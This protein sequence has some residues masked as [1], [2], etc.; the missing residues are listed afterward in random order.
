M[1]IFLV[2]LPTIM[3]TIFPPRP[4]YKVIPSHFW[5]DTLLAIMPIA[6]I[7]GLTVA[8]TYWI[9][10]TIYPDR[11][12]HVA[13]VT[14]LTATFFGVYMVFLVARMSGVMLD[15]KAK[16]AR[17]LYLFAVI[18]VALISFGTEFAR[19]FFDFSKPTVWIVWPASAVIILAAIVQWQL[20]NDRR[21][22]TLSSS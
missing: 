4:R 16:I 8:F 18:I 17:I 12:L 15:K 6:L 14:V 7:T 20:A 19:D 1:N 22:K 5:R 21:K 11:P 9:I 10:S 2:T 3:W 13:T